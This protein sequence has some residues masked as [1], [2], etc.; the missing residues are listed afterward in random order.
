MRLI[1]LFPLISS[2]LIAAQSISLS[3]TIAI[4]NSQYETGKR[5][6]ISDASVRAP[7]SKP[8]TSDNAGQFKLE[9]A[10]VGSGTPV[11]LTVSKQGYEV[12]NYSE[13]QSVILGRTSVVEVVMADA[14]KLAE[15]QEQFYKIATDAVAASYHRR[16]SALKDENIALSDR[17]AAFETASDKEVGTL[18][19]AIDVLT[20]ERERAL[21]HAVELARQFATTDLDGTSDLFRQAYVAFQ[22]GDVDATLL[23]LDKERLDA[24]Y[25]SARKDRAQGVEL[26]AQANE[27]IRQVYKSFGLKADVLSATL[28]HRGALNTLDGMAAM[29]K[30]DPDAFTIDVDYELAFRRGGVLRSMARETEAAAEYRRGRE[31]VRE[32]LGDDHIEQVRF[33]APWANAM[34]DSDSLAKAFN[35]L[36]EASTLM[37]GHE[38]EKPL[39]VADLEYLL[40]MGLRY[41]GDPNAAMPHLKKCLALRQAAHP[42]DH[43]EVQASLHALMLCHKDLGAYEQAVAMYEQADELSRTAGSRPSARFMINVG[44]LYFMMGDLAKAEPAMRSGRS[45]LMKEVG[46]GHPHVFVASINLSLC[47]AER[48]KFK[49]SLAILDSTLILNDGLVP[50]E[51]S[52]MAG[53]HGVRGAILKSMGEHEAALEAYER[54]LGIFT[55]LYGATHGSIADVRLAMARIKAV[56]GDAEGA[57]LE[58]SLAFEIRTRNLGPDNILILDAGCRMAYDLVALGRDTA[59]VELFRKYLPRV[60]EAVGYHDPQVNVVD[61][62]NE[63]GKALYRL[64]ELDSAR[65]VLEGTIA[66]TPHQQ[67]EWYLSKIA[68]DQDRKS[69][70]LEHLIKSARLC[71]EDTDPEQKKVLMHALKELAV[72]LDRKD[73]LQEFNLTD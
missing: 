40:G 21:G 61:Y 8:T 66:I 58:D 33:L 13:V 5:Q 22:R 42:S 44:G 14:H 15:A 55:K 52:S 16:L 3:G 20:A 38:E 73:V 6:F 25:A 65:A 37:R 35:L 12:V 71:D 34:L 18:H 10:G 45:S 7:L 62:E 26:V 39:W 31:R 29:M 50:E 53:M 63:L 43:P 57:L 19:D 51:H 70:S 60:K 69:D 72:R 47:V 64:G 46:P 32:H 27:A 56:L 59:A 67:A 1:A 4:Q 48:G 17:L 24:D 11:R 41:S 9:F 30:A 68:M 23:L 36:D 28:D 49:E 54:C 2:A